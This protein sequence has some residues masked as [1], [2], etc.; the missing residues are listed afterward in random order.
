VLLRVLVVDDEPIA[1]RVL[2]EE[3][4][5]L[6]DVRIVGEAEN[7]AE[8]LAEIGTLAP[9][10]V[11]LDWQMPG[12]TGLD[13]L[14]RL[15]SGGRPVVV[16][17]TAYYQYAQEALDRGAADYLMKPVDSARLQRAVEDARLRIQPVLR[18][19]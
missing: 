2:I 18:G 19:A 8:A 3:L 11:F 15:G 16:V 1:R 12:M 7:G 9:D 6:P 14:Q 5:L 13:V 17:V 10:L 4:A